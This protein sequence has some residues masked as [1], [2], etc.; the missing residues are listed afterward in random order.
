MAQYYT[1]HLFTENKVRGDRVPLLFVTHTHTREEKERE[2]EEV[3]G[4]VHTHTYHRIKVTLSAF[5]QGYYD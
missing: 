2:R 5:L 1:P 4:V 3:G